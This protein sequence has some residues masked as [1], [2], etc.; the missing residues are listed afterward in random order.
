MSLKRPGIG[1]RESRLFE[2]NE[3]LV[4]DAEG[5]RALV[6]VVKPVALLGGPLLVKPNRLGFHC[7][8]LRNGDREI[9]PINSRGE[10]GDDC[11]HGDQDDECESFHGCD[12]PLE[13]VGSC[14]R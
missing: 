7:R 5:L 9:P 12:V 8:V 3:P 10:Q 6:G 2:G 13:A 4:G 1:K 11:N 14:T